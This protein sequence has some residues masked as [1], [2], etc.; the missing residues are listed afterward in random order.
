MGLI[1]GIAAGALAAGASAYGASRSANAQKSAT[2]SN[3]KANYR[4]FREARGEGGSAVLPL[5]LRTRGGRL[6]EDVMGQDAA[7]YYTD[8]ANDV[9]QQDFEDA[10]NS[11]ADARRSALGLTD[12]IFN[13]GVTN[14]MMTN[15]KP[16]KDARVRF[17][18]QSSIDALNKTL[19]DIEAMQAGKGYAGDSMGKRRLMFDANRRMYSDVGDAN[20]QNLMEERSAITATCNSRSTRFSCRIRWRR[21]RASSWRCRAKATRTGCRRGNSR[22]GSSTSARRSRSRTRKCPLE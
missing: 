22:C 11:T 9:S 12:E 8:T 7:N 10:A 20:L 14:R 16:V 21:R 17:R 4:M 19:G 6:L 13:G 5:Y 18:R 15:F 3:N 1:A 2:I